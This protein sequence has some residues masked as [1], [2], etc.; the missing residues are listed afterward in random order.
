[1][2]GSSS[3]P[4][5][6]AHPRPR[7]T[8]TRSR[9]SSCRSGAATGSCCGDA[10]YAVSLLAGQGASLAIGGA[11]V[12]AE[13]LARVGPIDTALRRYEQLWRP[14]AEEKQQIARSGVR[15]FLPHSRAQLRARHVVMGLS[16]LPGIDRYIARALA[17]KST[18]LVRELHATSH[19]PARVA[20]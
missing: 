9:R 1:L 8:T 13:Q 14:V 17:G 4:W 10:A 15:W 18:A 3:K 16:C 5:T 20:G 6:A 19:K 11:Y 12:L 2:A 7:C